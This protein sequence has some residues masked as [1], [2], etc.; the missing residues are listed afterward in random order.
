MIR[1][2]PYNSND[3][4]N[5]VNWINNERDFVKWCANLMQ[6]PLTEK[7]LNDMKDTL[8]QKEKAWFVTAT[9]EEGVPV[10]FML[11][12]HM[13]Y[14]KESIHFGFVIVDSSMRNK[15]YGKQMMSLAVKYVFEILNFKRIT[16]RVFDNNPIAHSCYKA[17]GFVDEEYVE[18]KFPYKDE[19]WGSYGMAL[20]K[21][22]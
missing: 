13:D 16:L 3:A 21:Q 2:R 11:M 19:L 17:L 12:G 15:G 8:E 20:E 14:A 6:Y 9:N 4:K 10:G 5:I 18:K 7:I 1:L 22:V